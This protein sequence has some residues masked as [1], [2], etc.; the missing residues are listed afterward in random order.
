MTVIANFI[1]L[2]APSFLRFVF[3]MRTP[4]R[5]GLWRVYDPILPV[6]LVNGRMSEVGGRIWFRYDAASGRWQ[7]SQ[8]AE[9]IEEKED[10]IW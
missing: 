3:G 7:Y 6:R 5:D 2:H 10:V 9:T 4:P 8:D 1:G